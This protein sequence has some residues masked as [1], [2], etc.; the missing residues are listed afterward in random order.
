VLNAQQQH[1]PP[2]VAIT[3]NGQQTPFLSDEKGVVAVHIPWSAIG[4]GSV[5]ATGPHQITSVGGATLDEPLV[6]TAQV[7]S[8]NYAMQWQSDGFSRIGISFVNVEKGG[9]TSIVLEETDGNLDSF[10]HI[11][12]G[13]EVRNGVG[14]EASVGATAGVQGKQVAGQRIGAGAKAKAGVEGMISSVSE[15]RYRYT[16]PN[17]TEAQAMAQY[18]LVTDGMVG[19]LSLPLVNLLGFVEERITGE[20]SLDETY[21]YGGRGLDIMVGAKA[22]AS[23]TAG[24]IGGQSVAGIGVEAGLGGEGHGLLTWAEYPQDNE[25]SVLVGLTGQAKA[26]AKIE[27]GLVVK[28]QS[29]ALGAAAFAGLEASGRIGGSIELFYG[30]DDIKRIE[31]ETTRQGSWGY[32]IGTEFLLG[33]AEGQVNLVGKKVETATRVTLVGVNDVLKQVITTNDFGQALFARKVDDLKVDGDTF[34]DLLDA[35]SAAIDALQESGQLTVTYTKE[36]RCIASEGGGEIELEGQ[37]GT[38]ALRVALATGKTFERQKVIVVERGA[39]VRGGLR[40]QELYQDDAFTP[41]TNRTMAMLVQEIHDAMGS[42]VQE[43]FTPLLEKI[44]DGVE[45]VIDHLS[46]RFLLRV[47][48]NAT[49]EGVTE[50]GALTW[51]WWGPLPSAKP[52]LLSPAQ[53]AVRAKIARTAQQAAR[54]DYGIGGFYQLTPP[55][56]ILTEPADLTIGY[57]DDEVEGMEEEALAVYTQDQETGQWLL[58]GGTVDAVN[59]RVTAQVSTLA[60][61]T[62]APR[63]PDGE[64]DLLPGSSSLPADGISTVEVASDTVWNNDGTPIA[65]GTLFD[66]WTT[67]GSIQTDDINVD[68]DGLQVS[69][70]DGQLT[71]TVQAGVIAL[72]AD[73]IA[74]SVIG[75]AVGRVTI[76]LTDEQA[77]DQPA[78]PSAVWQLDKVLVS[79]IPNQALDVTGY[80]I[81]YRENEPGPPYDGRAALPGQP[82]PVTVG[83]AA[84]ADVLGL[85]PEKIYYF[86]VSS[87]DVAGNESTLSE[88][89]LVQ[90]EETVETPAGLVG[91]FDNNGQV[92]FGDFFLFVERFGLRSTDEN[93]DV[94]FDLNGDLNIDFGDFFVFV[95]Q[96]GLEARG[97]LMHLGQIY[98]GLPD[99]P[100]LAQNYPNP[101]NASTVLSYAV[102]TN[103]VIELSIYD[104]LGQKV[105]QLVKESVRPGIYTVHWDGRDTANHPLASGLYLAVLQTPHTRAVRQMVMLR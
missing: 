80:R 61:Y 33:D 28:T 66:I 90:T 44:Q 10:N 12:I 99:T 81:H 48:A 98:L 70:Q 51:S 59:N 42:I 75:K 24:V 56:E 105:R 34:M 37:A 104:V 19:D 52:T 63:I 39:W 73:I 30:D 50:L 53:Y 64:F 71:F 7:D 13:R 96:F 58:V 15:D 62:L 97:K 78:T 14:A 11:E 40:P 69:A 26:G 21:V 38:S 1:G 103:A 43:A 89:I 91:D 18:M 86:A 47:A 72:P 17:R 25:G 8:R 82:S 9:G 84:T 87:F 22:E 41:A 60:L 27:A 77:P 32:D 45:T 54:L 3:V 35:M 31:I 6:F 92:Q 88:P 36:I 83:L 95:E 68:R 5:G 100:I 4:N 79:W 2:G 55:G 101:F 102:S 46:G 94:R 16:Y 23:A 76:E 67:A 20:N 29:S 65:D 93:F 49:Q 57:T 74:R 85:D